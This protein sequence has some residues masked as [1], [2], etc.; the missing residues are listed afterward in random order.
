[1]NNP[2]SPQYIQSP[3]PG[4][5]TRPM[6]MGT[7]VHR[8]GQAMSPSAY[9]PNRYPQ[10]QTPDKQKAA[11]S[12]IHQQQQHNEQMNRFHQQ[13]QPPLQDQARAHAHAITNTNT[14]NGL[15]PNGMPSP[16]VPHAHNN[17]HY[18][19]P[20]AHNN[21]IMQA[22]SMHQTPS[23][24]SDAAGQMIMDEGQG[25]GKKPKTGLKKLLSKMFSSPNIKPRDPLPDH[26]IE[27]GP[28][29]VQ[30]QQQPTQNQNNS[31]QNTVVKQ[32][33][34][35][36]QNNAVV[37]NIHGARNGQ[38]TNSNHNN[39][40]SHNSNRGAAPLHAQYNYPPALGA[41]E[42]S[43]P[44]NH[45]K[46]AVVYAHHH[47]SHNATPQPGVKTQNQPSNGVVYAQNNAAPQPGVKTQNHPSNA[48]MHHAQDNTHTTK[49][50]H[51]P[52]NSAH[53]M[54][55]APQNNN[56]NNN[57]I[58][59]P[60]PQPGTEALSPVLTPMH[61]APITNTPQPQPQPNRHANAIANATSPPPH[62]NN[63]HHVHIARQR[64]PPMEYIQ[65]QQPHS[66]KTGGNILSPPQHQNQNQH[67]QAQNLT[68]MM[69]YPAAQQASAVNGMMGAP[70]MM[71]IGAV[72]AKSPP[73][74]GANNKNNHVMMH[75]GSS[76]HVNIHTNARKDHTPSNPVLGNQPMNVCKTPPRNS[77]GI[78]TN[79]NGQ[80]MSPPGGMH[81]AAPSGAGQTQNMVYNIVQAKSPGA[82]HKNSTSVVVLMN[83]QQQQAQKS[84]LSPPQNMVK[85]AGGLTREQAQQQK[86]PHVQRQ[87]HAQKQQQQ[88]Q[89]P[90]HAVHDKNNQPVHAMP[91]QQ[92]GMVMHTQQH[93][94]AHA[95]AQAYP[96]MAA[97][98][99]GMPA[100]T[101]TTNNAPQHNLNN[102]NQ[103][104]AFNQQQNVL[105]SPVA[106]GPLTSGFPAS[107]YRPGALGSNACSSP[108]PRSLP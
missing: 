78:I 31:G 39:H 71:T 105:G 67:D 55:I 8:G 73:P 45:P 4:A 10:G 7:P 85:M 46:N 103:N 18:H 68:M 70:S 90:S 40:H 101:P 82:P 13:Q 52:P 56:N 54:H 84:A 63:T 83:N 11:M 44:Q 86:Q 76:P 100:S 41:S 93:A 99:K 43:G 108:R 32:P 2:Q 9:D 5:H 51:M 61:P 42:A 66:N 91:H 35:Q 17:T 34:T 37:A 20:H 23:V 25:Q 88:Q 62:N 49:S 89:L 6:G 75:P 80:I 57:I 36:T 59:N 19:P 24:T 106:A 79:V 3:A 12:P 27:G 58:M 98:N 30:Q 15:A 33:A 87:L 94:H 96:N 95:H 50:A 69:A 21:N 107:P 28:S 64:A 26:A 60:T 53:A 48:A 102:N 104:N 14:N 29:T 72:A 81:S 97:T 77:N 1:M 38:G 22:G 65:Q 74:N 16:N 47:T 92:Q